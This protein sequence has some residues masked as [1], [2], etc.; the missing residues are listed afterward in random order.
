MNSDEEA[1]PDD[2][3]APYVGPVVRPTPDAGGPGVGP[4]PMRE[5]AAAF[6]GF[7]VGLL[8]GAVVSPGVA[9]FLAFGVGS[10][11]AGVASVVCAVLGVAL[12][13]AASA[14]ALVRGGAP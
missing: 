6:G 14:V 12:G 13:C 1:A 9:P 5:E 11:L 8:L 4:R 10:E 3:G 2:G 7:G